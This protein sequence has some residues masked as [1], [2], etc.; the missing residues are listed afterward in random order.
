[1]ANSKPFIFDYQNGTYGWN[2]S[3]ER[4][5]DTFHPFNAMGGSEFP[6]LSHRGWN[7]ANKVLAKISANNKFSID[8]Y[9]NAEGSGGYYSGICVIG[10]P[11]LS[12]VSS[13]NVGYNTNPNIDANHGRLLAIRN[14]TSQPTS[15][16]ATIEDIQYPFDVYVY[17]LGGVDYGCTIGG[18]IRF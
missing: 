9:V 14:N 7:R 3:D 5:A 17:A 1:M 15:V 8:A 4:G 6:L 10:V 18:T 12:E 2:E 11:Y 13:F 16:T